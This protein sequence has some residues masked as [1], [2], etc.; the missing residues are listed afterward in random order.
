MRINQKLFGGHIYEYRTSSVKM[1]IPMKKKNVFISLLLVVFYILIREYIYYSPM[2]TKPPEILEKKISIKEEHHVESV[3]VKS[4]NVQQEKTTQQ[5]GRIYTKEPHVSH[6]KTTQ[7][8]SISN[9]CVD[10]YDLDPKKSAA[11]S[12]S[13]IVLLGNERKL[14]ELRDN[15]TVRITLS[16]G[17]GKAK[18]V[19]GDQVRVWMVEPAKK[20]NSTGYVTD[21]GNGTYTGHLKALWVGSPVIRSAIAI[22][23]EGIGVRHHALKVPGKLRMVVGVFKSQKIVEETDCGPSLNFKGEFCNFTAENFGLPWFCARPK[24]TKLLCHDWVKVRGVYQV[25]YT[26]QET[27]MMKG[28]NLLKPEINIK[29]TSKDNR[30]LHVSPPPVACNRFPSTKT[31]SLKSPVGF[32]FQGKWFSTYC[33]STIEDSVAVYTKC[34]Q[35][36]RIQIIGDS[37]SEHWLKVLEQMLHFQRVGSFRHH[38]PIVTVLKSNNITMSW[39]T[40]GYPFLHPRIANNKAFSKPVHVYLDKIPKGSNDIVIFNL[41]VHFNAY[42]PDILQRQAHALVN[43]V[44]SVKKRSPNVTIA[45]KGFHAFGDTKIFLDDYWASV[46]ELIIKKEFA[47]ILDKVIYLNCWDIT[48]C[49]ENENF[50]N[51]NEIDKEM[52]HIALSHICR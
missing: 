30:E 18:S 20:A 52:V 14:F 29:V 21:H 9:H 8:S 37:T 27:A 45:F 10:S 40:H 12:M 16:D 2:L 41:Y 15:I 42:T 47:S 51:S 31:W 6:E 39:F 33:S 7:K 49:T 23:C 11:A 35:N 13:K 5:L 43:S 50:H 1:E 4:Q 48:V 46:Y 25:T 17:N 32:F 36:R 19:G 22:T 38:R 44:H 34:L 28:H 3:Y 24:N 26:G